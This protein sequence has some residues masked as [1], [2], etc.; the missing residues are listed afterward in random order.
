MELCEVKEK[1]IR[2]MSK[3]PESKIVTA[4]LLTANKVDQYGDSFT[5]EVLALIEKDVTER[6]E[7]GENIWAHVGLDQRLETIQGRLTRVSMKGTDVLE[8]TVELQETPAGL[9]AQTIQDPQIAFGG[10]CDKVNEVERNG[11]K[12]REIVKAKLTMVSVVLPQHKIW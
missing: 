9:D 10:L 8:A 4:P 5:P 6:L 11:K 3:V 12:I 1:R 2:E 7:K